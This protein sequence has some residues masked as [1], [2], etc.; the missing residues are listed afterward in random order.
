[1][2][3][4]K[5]HIAKLIH[6]ITAWLL[7]FFLMLL[8]CCPITAMAAEMEQK[9]VRVGF[10]SCPFNIKDETGH[11]SGYAYDYQQ[12]IATYTGWKYEYVEASWP[13]LLRML[14]DGELDDAMHL[15]LSKNRYYNEG[16]YQ[17]YL[18]NNASRSI[19]SDELKWLQEHG[20]IRVGYLDDYLA[21]CDKEDASGELIGALQEF[22]SIAENC[23]YNASLEFEPIA[24]SN[25]ADMRAALQEGEVDCIFPAYFDRYYAEQSQMYVTNS[26]AD[27][28]M[29]A[30]VN[31]VGFNEN[32]E[33][34][35]V[36]PNGSIEAE[37][38]VENNYPLW[39]VVDA[40]SEQECIDMVRK[41][42]ADCTVFS[43]NRV[44]YIIPTNRYDGLLCI[45]SE[46]P[47]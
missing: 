22:L 31:S 9:T 7:C 47:Q 44:D 42:E 30:L 1:M 43:A 25:A 21:Y 20:T 24:F 14:K 29:I 8:S 27:T 33:N 34:I 40:V 46:Y 41:G 38:Y 15:L 36:I 11:M 23:L 6:R 37:L 45:L 2:D 12:D 3:I 28:G 35:A 32:A 4:C 19:P 39:T 13:E 10:Y 5:R 16:L 26:V 18:N 17:K